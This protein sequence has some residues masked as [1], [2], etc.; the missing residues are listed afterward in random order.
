[1]TSHWAVVKIKSDHSC[2]M[3]SPVPGAEQSKY[4]HG[5][6]GILE[7]WVQILTPLLIVHV[8]LGKS[9]QLSEPQL[10]YKI[11]SG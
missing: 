3:R 4:C 9:L 6:Q 5:G 10:L 8:T 11:E 7:F 1:M 2:K